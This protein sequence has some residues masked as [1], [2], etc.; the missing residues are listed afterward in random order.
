MVLQALDTTAESLTIRV[1]GYPIKLT[2]LNKVFWPA[3]EDRRALLKRDLLRYYVQ[4]APYVLPHLRDR[5][6]TMTRFP[7][8]IHGGRFYQKSPKESAPPFVERFV[9]VFGPQRRGRRIFRL[10]QRGDVDLAG[11][12]GRPGIAREPHA[13]HQPAR[14]AGTWGRVR[15]QI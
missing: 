9:V 8:G 6:V 7:N 5:P 2:N 4:I 10:Q 15:R 14:R 3:W 13:H 1:D 11:A 12:T